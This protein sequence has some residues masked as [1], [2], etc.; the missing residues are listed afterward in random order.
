M[1]KTKEAIEKLL[2]EDPEVDSEPPPLIPQPPEETDENENLSALE[3]LAKRRRVSGD[4]DNRGGRGGREGEEGGEGEEGE[5][6]LRQRQPLH[7]SHSQILS[8]SSTVLKEWR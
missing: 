6:F 7:L 1:T 3:R 2:Y 5:M 4:H 8:W